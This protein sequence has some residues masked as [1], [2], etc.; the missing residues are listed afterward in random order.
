MKRAATAV[1]ERLGTGM[2]PATAVLR[3]SGTYY[4]ASGPADGVSLKAIT[5]G[6]AAWTTP[7]RRFVLSEGMHLLLNAGDYEIEIDSPRVETGTLCVFFEPGFLEDI[8]THTL[9]ADARAIEW[10]EHIE[11]WDARVWPLL[12]QL[13][14]RGPSEPLVLAIGETLVGR[15]IVVEDENETRRRVLRGR[16]FL[17]SS[18]GERV[19][20][21]DAARAARLSPYHFHRAFRDAFGA[22]PHR[23]LAEHRLRRAAHL[24]HVTSRT[25]EEIAGDCGFESAT[26]F[27]AAF[28]RRFGV[29]PAAYRRRRTE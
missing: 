20:L 16:D 4:A 5:R 23:Y 28:R 14:A 10:R 13:E 2:W 1:V 24:L 19:R 22:P 11:P 29:P 17:L 18:L 15:R 7:H 21:E 27:S 26:S 9:D 8:A 25:A 12:L 6:T 3:G